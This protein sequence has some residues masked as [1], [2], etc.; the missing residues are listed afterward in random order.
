VGTANDQHGQI[1]CLPCD[2]GNY[3][4]TTGKATCHIC[5]AGSQCSNPAISPVQCEV[6]QYSEAGKVSCTTCADGHYTTLIGSTYCN[7]CGPGKHLLFEM[8]F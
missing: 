2:D 7:I 1:L 6:D 3:T 8:I 4:A 5:P